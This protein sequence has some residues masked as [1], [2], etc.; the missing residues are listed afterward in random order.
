VNVSLEQ[1][2]DAAY[3]DDV[4]LLGGEGPGAIAVEDWATFKGTHPHEVLCSIGSRVERRV[5]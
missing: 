4:V 1:V 3:G 5:R 2:P